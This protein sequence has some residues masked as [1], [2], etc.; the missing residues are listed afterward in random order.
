MQQQNRSLHRL[1][2]AAILACLM[3]GLLGSAQAQV[4][5]GHHYRPHYWDLPTNF[6][7]PF[8]FP[9]Q[10]FL[11]NSTRNRYD[12]NGKK[13][14]T[15]TDTDTLFGFTIVP[16]FFKFDPAS[17]WAYAFSVSTYE[18]SSRTPTSR[19]SGIGSLI[20]SFTGWTKPTKN[21]TIGYDILVG[22]PFSGSSKLDSHTWDYYLRG[23]YDVNV[24]NWNIEAVVGYHTAQPQW[25]SVSK[26]K[27]EYHL[28]GRVGYDIQGVAPGGMRVTPYVSAD[29][30][31][32][33]DNSS[34]VFNA[35]GGVMVAHKDFTIWSVGFS[36]TVNGR[37][38]PETKAILAQ[39]W[40]PF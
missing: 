21:S 17:E 18:F 8:T 30:Q 7:K 25:N 33:E 12:G 26:P 9:G 32:N 13:V 11:Y 34:N 3:A 15:G 37:N 6:D 22:T 20:P 19:L 14:D 40:M 39:V 36:K 2:R 38:V 28:N 1:F 31:R 10:T 5:L 27:D 35:G 16:H 23:F 24:N 29:Y 4:A